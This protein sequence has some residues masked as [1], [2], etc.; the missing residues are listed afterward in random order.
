[1]LT[2]VNLFNLRASKTFENLTLRF[3]FKSNLKILSNMSRVTISRGKTV[4]F[5][6]NVKS[7]YDLQGHYT[8]CSREDSRERDFYWLCKDKRE[9]G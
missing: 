2:K 9:I 6:E 4:I 3:G 8:L 1:M 7:K 5:P